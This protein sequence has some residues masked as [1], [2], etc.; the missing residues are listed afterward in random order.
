LLTGA[1]GNLGTTLVESRA[2]EFVPVGRADWPRLPALLA[3]DVDAVLHAA[4]DL[5]TPITQRPVDVLDANLMATMRLLEACRAIGVTKFGYVSSCAV[6]GEDM[7][8]AEDSACHPVTLNGITKLLNERIVEAFCSELGIECQ[9]YRVFNMFGG[10]DGFSILSHLRRA[11]D[12][13]APFALNNGGAAQRDFI[14]VADV[15]RIVMMLLPRQ[16]PGIHMNVGTGRTTRIS[17]IVAV[18]RRLHPELAIEQRS[19]HE[20]EY[21]R[22]DISRLSS[23]VEELRFVDVMDFVELA[24]GE[25]ETATDNRRA[26]R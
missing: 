23:T 26:A 22:A 19:A 17:D 4:W 7:N 6:Y 14:H 2:A 16:L 1:T 18:I 8:T 9:I 3:S 12:H 5:K 20:A 21:S 25:D 11:I 13:R 15:A 10:N 24:F